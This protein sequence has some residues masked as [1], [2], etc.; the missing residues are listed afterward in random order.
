LLQIKVQ[1]Y[2]FTAKQGPAT[3][4][5]PGFFLNGVNIFKRQNTSCGEGSTCGNGNNNSGNNNGDVST[6]SSGTSNTDRN[7]ALGVGLGVGLPAAIA[8]IW[9]MYRWVHKKGADDGKKSLIAPQTNA[10]R[11]QG[12]LTSMQ[13]QGSGIG[14]QVVVGEPGV[15][16]LESDQRY[17]A[18]E[19]G[20]SRQ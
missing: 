5:L 6:D 11:Q 10:K 13:Q 1:A 4:I 8:A 2:T 16:E 7:I 12:N 9:Q 20:T 3:Y 19:L 17:Q 18:V 15:P 14:G